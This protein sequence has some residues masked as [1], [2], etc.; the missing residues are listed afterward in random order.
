MIWTPFNKKYWPYQVRLSDLP[1]F[2][3]RNVEPAERFCYDNF[4]TS[5]WR[6]VSWYFAFKHEADFTFFMLRWG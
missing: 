4:K 1:N 6:N 3:M 5:E 2:S